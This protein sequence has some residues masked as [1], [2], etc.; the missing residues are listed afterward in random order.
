LQSRNGKKSSRPCKMHLANL[1]LT[2]PNKSLPATAG[3]RQSTR[4]QN[5]EFAFSYSLWLRCVQSAFIARAG[6]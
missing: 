3:L 2:A 1:M 4:R 6:N 5:G